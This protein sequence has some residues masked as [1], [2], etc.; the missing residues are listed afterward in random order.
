MQLAPKSALAKSRKSGGKDKKRVAFVGIGRARDSDERKED[1]VGTN[2][3][4]N[5]AAAGGADKS[6]ESASPNDD[7]IH[8]DGSSSAQGSSVVSRIDSPA[9]GAGT[10]MQIRID[11]SAPPALDA[12]VAKK[13]F[14]EGLAPL[15][16][17]GFSGAE[18][19]E[20]EGRVTRSMA[21][22]FAELFVKRAKKDSEKDPLLSYID[23]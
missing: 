11:P 22:G 17:E 14:A 15:D 7:K 13:R 18:S 9:R 19:E 8:S 6:V 16:P 4:G 20:E 10:T 3:N 12:M 21:E 5:T 23:K 1:D 2:A